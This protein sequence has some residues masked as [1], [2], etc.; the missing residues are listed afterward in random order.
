MWR[1]VHLAQSSLADNSPSPQ[2]ETPDLFG[3][4]QQSEMSQ[5]SDSVE[6]NLWIEA[7]L[8]ALHSSVTLR[9]Q[10]EG[11]FDLK[12]LKILEGVKAYVDIKFKK[13]DALR[14]ALRDL[15]A[16]VYLRFS[17]YLTHLIFWNGRQETLD[18]VHQLKNKVL[19]ISPHWVF[20]CFMQKTRL[21]ETPYLLYGVTGLALPM[22][23]MAMGRMGTLRKNSQGRDI[24]END[25]SPSHSQIVYAIE[26]LS[27]HLA[28]KLTSPASD[29]NIDV[30]ELISPIVDR[31]RK[32]LNELSVSK[33]NTLPKVPFGQSAANTSSSRDSVF[34]PQRSVKSGCSKVCGSDHFKP[35]PSVPTKVAVHSSRRHTVSSILPSRRDHFAQTLATPTAESSGS[36]EVVNLVEVTQSEPLKRRG[37]PPINSEQLA[38]YTPIRFHK[39]LQRRCR[40]VKAKRALQLNTEKM[41]HLYRK[42]ID[43]DHVE[44]PP[45]R[46]GSLR[47]EHLKARPVVVRTRSAILNELQNVPSSTEFVKKQRTTK[48][49]KRVGNI[50]LSGISKV[51][52][53]TVVAIARNLGVLKIASAVD[54]QTRYVVSD[55]EGARTVSVMRALVKGIPVVTVE[56]AY[57][58]LEVGGWLKG[59]DYIVP[60]W[61]A[62]RK[63]WEKGQMARLFSS[64]GPF[65]V[66]LKSK[67]EAKHLVHL[68]RCCHGKLTDSMNRA[69]IFVSPASEWETLM[70]RRK[71]TDLRATYITEQVLLDSICECRINFLA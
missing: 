30:V 23:L 45:G 55:E 52:R 61:K 70:S 4:S 26:T 1:P 14:Q 49:R 66:S 25:S 33:N 63:A 51:E 48:K 37:R 42:M 2:F 28:S 9:R 41:V 8:N 19:V 50:V 57:R 16:V 60:R 5:I 44:T 62:A 71:K 69:V 32:R 47:S 67:P 17:K 59:N 68:I 46:P 3:S 34:L 40:S 64:L 29:E 43:R 20:R 39:Y 53:E 56:W 31:V 58:S 13:A 35:H 38:E 15:G 21:D 54:E 65:Y 18:K 24:E 11:H 6:L 10:T 36:V 27:D 22:R 12:H 7:Q